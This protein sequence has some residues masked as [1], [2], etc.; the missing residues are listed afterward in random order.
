MTMRAKT[1]LARMSS[2][3][4]APRRRRVAFVTAAIVPALLGLALAAPIAPDASAMTWGEPTGVT[5]TLS[6]AA[7]SSLACPSASMCVVI[8]EGSAGYTGYDS[9]EFTFDPRPLL[10]GHP[11][12]SYP[13]VSKYEIDPHQE[14]ISLACSSEASCVATDAE[15]AVVTFDPA[16]PEGAVRTPLTPGLRLNKI[17]CISAT[18]CVAMTQNILGAPEYIA[19]GFNP[20]TPSHPV[21]D[22]LVEYEVPGYGVEGFSCASATQC[23]LGLILGQG[24]VY[25]DPLSAGAPVIEELDGGQG[26]IESF[27]PIACTSE[28]RCHLFEQTRSHSTQAITFE[29]HKATLVRPV[30]IPAFG[31]GGVHLL[32][33]PENAR[34]LASD[35][36]QDV[37]EG[38]P[39][40]GDSWTLA[41]H[42]PPAINSISCPTAEEC[43]VNNDLGQ[44]MAGSGPI[45]ALATSEPAGPSPGSPASNDTSSSSTPGNGG[46]RPNASVA[47]VS[48][49]TTKA[50]RRRQISLRVQCVGVGIACNTLIQITVR[51]EHGRRWTTVLLAEKRVTL[52]AGT[53]E[54]I[55][56]ALTGKGRA[57]LTREHSVRSTVDLKTNGGN[58]TTRTVRIIAE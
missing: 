5:G 7:E 56:L 37:A 53:I 25:V 52:A 40:V 45:T 20:Q 38:D 43:V 55:V 28:I 31:E 14:L 51:V 47:H 34:C 1:S 8:G 54:R 16:H 30:I 17:H 2:A 26:A 48:S 57:L 41:T 36:G 27:G 6:P 15:G 21:F 4:G 50:S 10:P 18:E 9:Y 23:L 33:C 44:V 11:I 58:F 42:I 24:I 22:S 39:E 3:H 13:V 49:S 12:G 35:G 32:A 46:T 29:P 19:V